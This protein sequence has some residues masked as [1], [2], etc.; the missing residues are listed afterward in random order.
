MVLAALTLALTAAAPEVT[1][2]DALRLALDGNA[3]L[4]VSRAEVDVSTAQVPLAH[5]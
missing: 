2:E 1:L 3:Q 5:D 4:K